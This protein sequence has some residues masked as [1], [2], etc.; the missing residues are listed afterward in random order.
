MNDFETNGDDSAAALTA[1]MLS[2]ESARHAAQAERSEPTVFDT[3]SLPGVG[4]EV[5]TLKEGIAKGGLATFIILLVLNSLDELELAALTVLAP[6]IRDTFGVS[7]GTIV[8]ISSASASFFVLGAM[9]MGYL[10]DRF[11]RAPIIGIASLFFGFFVF[12]SGLAVNAFMLFWTRFGVGVAKS[13]TITVHSSLIADTY[14]IGVRGRMGALN[15]MV[16]RAIGVASPVLVGGIA[17]L[18]GGVEGWRW[19][20]LLLGIPV[21]IFALLS[22]R[23][24]EPV[25]GRWEKEDVLG[26]VHEDPDPVPI[27]IEA[28]F[29][30]LWKIRTMKTVVVAFA[31]MGFALFTAPVLRN[32]YLEEHFGLDAFGRGVVETLSGVGIIVAVPFVGK[33]FDTLYRADP[34]K[35]LATLG[36]LLLPV[37]V[38]IP[39]QY[40]MPN[41]ALFTAVGVFV[42]LLSGSAFAMVGPIIQGIVPYRLRGLG[43]ALLTLYIFF[44]GATGGGLLSALMS[45]AY[46][47]RTTVVTIAVPAMLIGGLMIL[48]GARFIKDDLSLVVAE[49]REEKEET[50]RQ[51]ENPDDIPVIQVNEVDFAYGHVQV[52]FD[53]S[54]EVRRGEVL[55]LL[56]TNGAGKSTILRLVAGLMTP[57]RGVVRL[58]GRTITFASAERRNSLGIHML[59]GGDGV[60]SDMTIADNITMAAWPYRSDKAEMQ[61]RVDRAWRL[62]PELEERS[63]ERADLLSG[64]QQQMLALAMTLIHDPEILIIDEL[65]I[66]LAPTVV[67]R[68]LVIIDELKREGMTMII[69]EQSLNVALAVADRAVFLEKGRVRFEGDAQELAERD[70]LAR[71]VFLGSEGG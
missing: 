61:R 50:E 9:P 46:G 21:G 1:A 24:P 29:A 35:A 49:L 3:E 30:R 36:M 26:A 54:F 8:F 66:G 44:V 60:F 17:A 55:A 51:A 31:A 33:R 69:V 18:A 6:D 71:A 59:A 32:L 23:I 19:S 43:T 58:N 41:V 45:N 56:G 7:D 25:R 37:S 2:E 15:T 64:G 68:L 65:S 13:N 57:E 28:A 16:G 39:I 34:S 63:N 10:A 62:F 14:P 70:D 4:A 47:P 40:Y 12:M 5:M 42:N 67:Q 27:S 22:F 53:V 20:Y 48:N 52:L 38:L 11:K